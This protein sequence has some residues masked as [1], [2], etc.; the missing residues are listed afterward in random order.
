VIAAH[1]W[2]AQ[3]RSPIVGRWFGLDLSALDSYRNGIL[4]CKSLEEKFDELRIAFRYM[5][6]SDTFVLVVLDQRLR[7][8]RQLVPEL[9]EANAKDAS[10]AALHN[11]PM[12]IPPGSIGVPFRRL[13]I[14]HYSTALE[15]ARVKGWVLPAAMPTVPPENAEVVR[16]L[17]GRSPQAK[18][19][20]IQRYA[21]Y[22]IAGTNSV[23]SSGGSIVSDSSGASSPTTTP[24]VAAAAGSRTEEE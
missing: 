17:S 19:P 15:H 14:Y 4:M 2:P 10:F 24:I 6:D 12:T 18:W 16:W 8:R 7:G 11:R 13:L 9:V 1:I 3:A 23:R 20:G 22:L 5:E 21:R